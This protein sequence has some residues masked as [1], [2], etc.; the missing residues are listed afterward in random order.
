MNNAVVRAL[1][2]RPSAWRL[3]GMTAD[4]AEAV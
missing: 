4:L 3:T 2:A 1:L